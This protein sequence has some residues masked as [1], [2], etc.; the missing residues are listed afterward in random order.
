MNKRA[1]ARRGM[2]EP[3]PGPWPRLRPFLASF[4]LTDRQQQEQ[5]QQQE[6]HENNKIRPI[7]SARTEA[8]R[9]TV[10]RDR[11]HPRPRDRQTQAKKKG[12]KIK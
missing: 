7:S 11:H 8:R 4:G 6:Q 5:Q 9:Y 1:G 3:G 2:G 12:K 10:G